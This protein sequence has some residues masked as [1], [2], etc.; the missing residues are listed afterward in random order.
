MCAPPRDDDNNSN[1][2]PPDS[3]ATLE[4]LPPIL[5]DGVEKERRVGGEVVVA[6]HTQLYLRHTC[7][8]Y[9]VPFLL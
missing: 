8:L 4:Q 9:Q 5:Q 3:F 2:H 7:T 1:N 6:L